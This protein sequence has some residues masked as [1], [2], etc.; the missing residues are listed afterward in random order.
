MNNDERYTDERTKKITG[1]QMFDASAWT[2]RMMR[3]KWSARW[4]DD[5]S[6]KEARPNELK[7]N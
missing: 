2:E 4:T 6:Q 5:E 1:T 3:I 7:Y